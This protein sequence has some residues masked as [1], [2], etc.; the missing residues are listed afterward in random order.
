[1]SISSRE[2][3]AEVPSHV[4]DFHLFGD[5]FS[6]SEMRGV[7]DEHAMLQRWLDVEAALAAAQAELGPVPRATA[8]AGR[9][10]AQQAPPITFGFKV[11]TWVA[12]GVPHVEG[13][14]EAATR[15]FVG[16]L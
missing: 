4:I 14:D 3:G 10:P 15:L 2:A 1:M 9:P 13:L 6:T 5:Q 11:A 8:V 12:E 16:Q 7:F